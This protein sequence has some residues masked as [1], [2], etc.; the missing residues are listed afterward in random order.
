MVPVNS[1]GVYTT[2]CT[3]IE[4][5]IRLVGKIDELPLDVC[6]GKAVVWMIYNFVIVMFYYIFNHIIR[7]FY[8][9]FI[10]EKSN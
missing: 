9:I 1:A 8:V 3:L 2:I 4:K 6:F 5:N 7:I 10:H